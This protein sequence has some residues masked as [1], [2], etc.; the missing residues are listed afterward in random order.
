MFQHQ[1]QHIA[2]ARAQGHAYADFVRSTADRVG[3]HAVNSSR[4]QYDGKSG[5]EAE[6]L[7]ND[8]PLRNPRRRRLLHALNTRN[9]LRAIDSGKNFTHGMRECRRL[10]ARAHY[11]GCRK[12]CGAGTTRV[13]ADMLVRRHVN[14]CGNGLA[15]TELSDISN[16]SDDL[17]WPTF[18]DLASSC[19]REANVNLLAN[20]ILTRKIPLRKSCIDHGYPGCAL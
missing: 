15:R 12:V 14:H 9:H 10:A 18:G 4:R 11:Q 16:Y 17:P 5:K 8:S 13:I 20:R 7:R 19:I 3:H 1:C 6:Y 2:R